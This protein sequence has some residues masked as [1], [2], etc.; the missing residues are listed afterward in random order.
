MVDQV[1]MRVGEAYFDRG[2]YSH[3]RN[4]F[5]ILS[6]RSADPEAAAVAAFLAGRSSMLLMSQ[7]GLDRSIELF[8][9]AARGHSRLRAHAR[10]YQALAK[11]N[12]GQ[13]E[14]AILLLEN[15]LESDPPAQIRYAASIGLATTLLAG[16]GNANRQDRAIA[17]LAQ[18]A[19]DPDAPPGWKNQA[20]FKW[21]KALENAGERDAA[22]SIYYEILMTNGI[23]GE[24]E[25]TFWYYKAGFD[26]I[27]LLKRREDWQSAARVYEQLIA[28]AGPRSGEAREQ[29]DRLRLEHFLWDP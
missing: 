14:E 4:H 24:S 1:R 19:R 12:L 5:E 21:A 15:L 28:A 27:T 23:P 8:E 16:E 13:A 2:I 20:G 6:R 7:E 26:L 10:F 29:L 9:K 17:L 11:N 18:V 3:A 22:A 25:E